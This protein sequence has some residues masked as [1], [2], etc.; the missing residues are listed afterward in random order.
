MKYDL[1]WAGVQF[2]PEIIALDCSFNTPWFLIM[3]FRFLITSFCFSHVLVSGSQGYGVYIY[4][5]LVRGILALPVAHYICSALPN[6][7]IIFQFCNQYILILI[8]E[9]FTLSCLNCIPGY[10]CTVFQIYACSVLLRCLHED[11]LF[12]L[13]F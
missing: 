8:L 1:T 7:V 3:A 6:L 5:Y 10:T 2:V 11:Y 9:I 13:Y 12:N 4:Q